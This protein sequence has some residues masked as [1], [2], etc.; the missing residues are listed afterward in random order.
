MRNA[1]TMFIWPTQ[2][3]QHFG[4]HDL[5]LLTFEFTTIFCSLRHG[6]DLE[7]NCINCTSGLLM[8]G[9]IYTHW[10]PRSTCNLKKDHGQWISDLWLVVGRTVCWAQG[11]RNQTTWSSPTTFILQIHLKK[12][13]GGKK[14]DIPGRMLLPAVYWA[15]FT[16]CAN[17][18]WSCF[19][20]CSQTCSPTSS[21]TQSWDSTACLS[22]SNSPSFSSSPL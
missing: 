20:P 9:L 1:K 11:G 18:W 10:L 21:S 17:C 16:C 2:V 3:L 5:E 6:C 22:A 14:K 4:V 19:F 12:L 7:R 15:A 13:R 8:Y